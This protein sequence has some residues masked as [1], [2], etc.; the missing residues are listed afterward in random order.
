MLNDSEGNAKRIM[1]IGTMVLTT[2][3]VL[4]EKGLFKNDS[5]IRNIG[6]VLSQLLQFAEDENEMGSFNEDGWK[7]TVVQ[8][9][10]DYDISIEGVAGVDQLFCDIRAHEDISDSE[11]EDEDRIT[12][13]VNGA[14]NMVICYKSRELWGVMTV[15]KL[16]SGHRR[17]WKQWNWRMEV[18]SFLRS[19]LTCGHN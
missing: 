14:V 17:S 11:D 1:L 9:W 15:E 8:K 12:G 16:N 7:A 4:I 5:E 19:P 2:I 3:D 18:G 13:M 10:I 6:L